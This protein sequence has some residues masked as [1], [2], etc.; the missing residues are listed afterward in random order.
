[1]EFLS[2]CKISLRRA[3]ELYTPSEQDS[4]KIYKYYSNSNLDKSVSW[5]NKPILLYGC[6]IRATNLHL[7][8]EW[9]SWISTIEI[10]KN[11]PPK[12]LQYH[13][14][15]RAE[16]ITYKSKYKKRAIKYWHSLNQTAPLS[17]KYETRLVKRLS[18]IYSP[19][20]HWSHRPEI[21]LLLQK[22]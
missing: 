10:C 6:K 7:D 15:D 18:C 12:S 1:M 5:N 21:F 14:Q 19:I 3:E 16:P 13:T 20:S 17:I 9:L 11:I 22:R 2:G 8:L 4:K